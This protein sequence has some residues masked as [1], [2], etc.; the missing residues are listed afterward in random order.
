MAPMARGGGMPG[1]FIG[2]AVLAAGGVTFLVLKDRLFA[3]SA[4]EAVGP[5]AP[6]AAPLG[7]PLAAPLYPPA[8][9][10]QPVALRP[11]LAAT[12]A[13]RPGTPPAIRA[14]AQPGHADRGTC[15]S[16]HLVVDGRG[17][18]VPAISALS[19]MR[20]PY[21]GVCSNCHRLVTAIGGADPAPAAYGGLAAA[22]PPAASPSFVPPSSPPLASAPPA[23][24]AVAAPPPLAVAAPSAA[25]ATTLLG[26][27]LAPVTPVSA[28]RFGLPAASTGL[29]VTGTSAEAAASGLRPGDLLLSLHGLRTADAEGLA[30][31]QRQAPST[32]A[33]VEVLRAGAILRFLLP[34]P[35][36][37]ASVEGSR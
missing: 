9:A 23:A 20:H 27:E 11:P 21:R 17:A 3:N 22:A 10:G 26:L 32:G 37:G 35:S 25:P 6:L 7:A 1:W 33:V 13:A 4:P 19:T 5:V 36:G 12:A 28:A 34:A 15:T 14:G 31:A 18:P 30:L 2:L 24:P 29:L 8:P 16:C